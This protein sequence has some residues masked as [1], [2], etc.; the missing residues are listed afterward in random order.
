MDKIKTQLPNNKS[1]YL[2][3][4]V[5]LI[6]VLSYAV[7]GLIGNKALSRTNLEVSNL[8]I[9][10][11]ELSANGTDSSLVDITITNLDT[12][13]LA[14]NIW[15]G[16]KITNNQMIDEEFS[17]FGWYSPSPN[18]SFYQ[19][20]QSGS[21]RFKIKSKI[22]GNIS[23]SVFAADPEQKNSGKYQNLNKEFTLSF[24]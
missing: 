21:V 19:T 7:W 3:M 8:N 20:D 16:L 1:L 4:A 9:G 2:G 10:K 15:V 11:S 13:S 12:G 14:S 22:A 6:L 23:Y 5:V 24:K 18:R 17:Y